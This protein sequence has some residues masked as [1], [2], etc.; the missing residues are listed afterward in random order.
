[1]SNRDPHGQIVAHE[2]PPGAAY[3]EETFNYFL[4]TE[5]ARAERSNRRL[6]ILLVTV[7][8]V[9]GRPIPIPRASA[10]RLFEGL[11][12]SLRDTDIVGWYRQG[13]AAGAVLSERAGTPEPETAGRVEQRVGEALGRRLPEKT[14]RS[15]R[16][17]VV[18]LGPRPV[19]N[20]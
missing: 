20:E 15:L 1:M 11:R 12:L 19:E 8:P 3:D 4:S 2:C 7:E 17:R 16:V 5:L 9:P 18:E 10:G 13:F 14:V 6:R